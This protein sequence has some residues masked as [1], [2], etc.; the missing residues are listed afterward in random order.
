MGRRR[1]PSVEQALCEALCN[2]WSFYGELIVIIWVLLPNVQVCFQMETGI[3]TQNKI[4]LLSEVATKIEEITKTNQESIKQVLD[5]VAHIYLVSWKSIYLLPTT[6]D[7]CSRIRHSLALLKLNTS[8][9]RITF[10]DHVQRI[11]GPKFY[12]I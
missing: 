5:K 6:Y 10:G 9:A 3:D 12:P 8:M 11:P 4:V 1:G 2:A 7:A